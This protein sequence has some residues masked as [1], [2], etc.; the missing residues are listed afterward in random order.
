MKR[1]TIIFLAVVFFSA[2]G[3]A[4]TQSEMNQDAGKAYKVADKKL[5]DVYQKIIKLYSKNTLFLKNLK[6]A[7]K[8]WVQFRDAQLAM[9]YPERGQGYYG[10]ILPMCQ[11][12]YL[13]ELTNKRVKELEEWLGNPAE[14]EGCAGTIGEYQVEE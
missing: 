13:T 4:Q 10:S 7:Q 3:L 5:N 2:V 11:A 12:I 9:R 6:I 8:L 1:V 14:D